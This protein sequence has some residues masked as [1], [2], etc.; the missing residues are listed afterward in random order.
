MDTLLHPSY[1]PSIAQCV[2]IANANALTFER[3]DN[4]NKQTYRN[5]CYIYA[6][7]G[8]LLLN[9]PVVHSQKNRQLYRD[10]KIA[11]SE[12]WQGQHWKSLQSAYKMSPFFEFYDYE[13]EPLFTKPFEYLLDFN[14]SC[15]EILCSCLELDT[16]INFTDTFELTPVDT[17]TDYRHLVQ[18]KK[19]P[20][21]NFTPYTQVFAQKHGWLPN[22]SILDL[23]FNE[24]P[25]S[26][27]YLQSQ[28]L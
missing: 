7:N 19:E 14:L 20:D 28:S 16:P 11:T 5:R 15:F 2:A 10:V 21:Y 22:L 25:N 26:I 24:G 8:K 9:I 23:L 17:L 12:N 4:F 1:F 27:N 6:A 13:L 3:C 18:A